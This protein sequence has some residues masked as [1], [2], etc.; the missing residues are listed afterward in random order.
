VAKPGCEKLGSK[1]E[2]MHKGLS[3]KLL[4]SGSAHLTH[5]W[6][7]MLGPCVRAKIVISRVLLYCLTN[8]HSRNSCLIAS[9]TVDFGRSPAK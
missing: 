9:F 4:T 6:V 3:P 2:C 5:M 7:P 8:I 1:Y